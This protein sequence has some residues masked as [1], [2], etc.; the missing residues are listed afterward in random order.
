VIQQIIHETQPE[1]VIEIGCKFGGT[2]LQL[3]DIMKTAAWD[4]CSASIWRAWPSRFQRMSILS[5]G[6]SSS[7]E[8]LAI[9]CRNCADFARADDDRAARSAMTRV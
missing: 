2:T 5:W 9:V 7:D 3:S 8:T 1:V 6:D 4:E